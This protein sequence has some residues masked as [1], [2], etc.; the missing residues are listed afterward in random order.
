ME[1]DAELRN[2]QVRLDGSM[3]KHRRARWELTKVEIE[4]SIL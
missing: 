4:R 1:E 2:M 3:Y